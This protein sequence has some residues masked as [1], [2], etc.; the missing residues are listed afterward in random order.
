M[1]EATTKPKASKDKNPYDSPT[2]EILLGRKGQTSAQYT[3]DLASHD[4]FQTYMAAKGVSEAEVMRRAV[5][6]L[7]EEE[8]V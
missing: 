4:F 7:R 8:I 3:M 5:N 1:T 6:A 2:L